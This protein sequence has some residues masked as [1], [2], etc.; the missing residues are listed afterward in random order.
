MTGTV[1]THRRRG[2]RRAGARLQQIRQR[3]RVARHVVLHIVLISAL[4]AE[5][6]VQRGQRAAAQEAR[7]L[8][9][10]DV[11]LLAR[12]AAEEQRGRAQRRA[13][14]RRLC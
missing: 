11:V 5:G 3:G 1:S 6:H 2:D 9:R 13:C 14:T 7:Q 10:V 8:S 12:A 4:A